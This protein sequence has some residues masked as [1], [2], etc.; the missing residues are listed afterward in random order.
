MTKHAYSKPMRKYR[1]QGSSFGMEFYDDLD[2]VKQ[3]I[4]NHSNVQVFDQ[5]T[6]QIVLQR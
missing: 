2:R 3:A 5:A 4:E 6:G 1:A